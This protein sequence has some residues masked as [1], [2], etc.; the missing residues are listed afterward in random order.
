MLAEN[1]LDRHAD[2][3]LGFHSDGQ[4]VAAYK[5]EH[6]STLM[7]AVKPLSELVTLEL[8]HCMPIKMTVELPLDTRLVYHLAPVTDI[9]HI[10]DLIRGCYRV[11]DE[12]PEE[13][14]EETPIEEPPVDYIDIYSA[15]EDLGFFPYSG[16]TETF[17][18]NK[19]SRAGGSK[20]IGAP[21]YRF[22]RKAFTY[23]ID[24]QQ[25]EISG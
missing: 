18:V 14:P 19:G 21:T 9:D 11:T 7:R 8:S 23:L 15:L 25:S 24:G 3:I 17:T 1:E 10:K 20:S 4:Q 6:L 16:K 12:V 2:D 5:V 22:R 13:V